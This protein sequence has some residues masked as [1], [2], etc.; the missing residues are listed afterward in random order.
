MA[1][2]ICADTRKEALTVLEMHYGTAN[3]YQYELCA[4][5]HT[6]QL[7]TIPSAEVLARLYPSESYWSDPESSRT[8][9]QS[10]QKALFSFLAGV[11]NSPSLRATASGLRPRTLCNAL[12]YGIRP[13]DRVLDVGCGA[14]H[15]VKGLGNLGLVEPQGVDPFIPGNIVFDNGAK[16]SLGRPSDLPASHFDVVTYHHSLEHMPDPIGA[17]REGASRLK[18]G[19]RCIVRVPTTDSYAFRFYRE[20]WVQLDAPRHLVIPSRKAMR[21]AGEMAG[22]ELEC[23]I[24]DSTML[25]F[26]G[27]EL[28]RKGISYRDASGNVVDPAAYFSRSQLRAFSRKARRL[29]RDGEGDQAIFSFRK[30]REGASFVIQPEIR[31]GL[32][33]LPLGSAKLP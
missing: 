6:L 11:T 20:L 21:A 22:L 26:W 28:Y 10:L 15:F 19:G 23:V 13:G 7:T 2:I 33:R 1:C 25:Q 32:A 30:A 27:S 12:S 16:V 18:L 17:L 8:A 31:Q 24:D 4:T 9:M 3:L 14:G 29:N 5:C